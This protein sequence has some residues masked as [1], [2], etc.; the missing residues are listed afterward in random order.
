[1]ERRLSG[2]V[3]G[4]LLLISTSCGAPNCLDFEDLGHSYRTTGQIPEGYQ[5]LAWSKS[6]YW[7][8]KGLLP[9]SGYDHGTIG[10]VSLFT[11]FGRDVSLSG[12]KFSFYGAYITSTWSDTQD[13]IV[14]GW[15]G[16]RRVYTKKI[17]TH[18]DR[19]YWFDF[20]FKEIDQL[21][22]LPLG[23]YIVI[24]NITFAESVEKI[25]ID[26]KPGS[27][28]N[29]VNLKSKGNIPVAILN[30]DDS[31]GLE[32]DP[33]TVRFG[34]G[35]AMPVR[36]A[37]EDIDGDGDLDMMLHFKTQAT[38]ISAGDTEATLTG[39]LFGGQAVEGTDSIVTV[40]PCK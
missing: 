9:G 39:Q 17:R 1:M 36:W 40:P 38:G 26:I 31:D 11:A 28:E 20:D 23:T 21:R 10:G 30:S 16:E 37:L 14:E 2:I 33:T 25:T 6:S 8:T 34:P 35:M 12:D 15:R 7:V 29:P 19:A 13:V 18:N 4:M 22:F 27:L 24:D 3:I 5:G 32:V